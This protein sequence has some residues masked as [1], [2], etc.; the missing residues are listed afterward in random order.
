MKHSYK[1]NQCCAYEQDKT[2]LKIPY[3]Y[4]SGVWLCENGYL[5]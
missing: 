5:C 3:Q 2:V 4:I 1:L